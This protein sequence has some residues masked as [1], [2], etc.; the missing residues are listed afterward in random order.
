MMSSRQADPGARNIVL[1][2]FMA[3]GKSSVGKAL[4]QELGW[5]FIDTDSW[6]EQ[7]LNMKIPDIF[8]K[9]GESCFR[10]EEKKCVGGLAGKTGT[11]IATGGGTVLD[12]DNWRDLQLLGNM[13]HLYTPLRTALARAGNTQD[14]P[15][16]ANGQNAIKQLYR[17]RLK[18]YKRASLSI[19]TAQKEIPVI[20]AEILDWM[21][22]GCGG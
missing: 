6:I 3:S 2:G 18:I 17:Q 7:D 16:L 1:I 13:I 21:K 11:V 4:A 10:L 9:Y 19:N 5:D 15:L 14:R 12:Q 8:Q 20:V 22:G